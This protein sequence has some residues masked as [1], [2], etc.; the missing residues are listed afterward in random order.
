MNM[1]NSIQTFYRRCTYFVYRGMWETPTTKFQTVLY[2]FLRRLF[3][4]TRLFFRENLQYRASALTYS[5]ILSLV[6]LLAIVFAIA[7]GFGL[8][9]FTE[10]WMRH[11]LVAKP[12]IIDTLVHFVQSYLEHTQ[13]GV[14]LGS[15]LIMLFWTLYNL[16]DSIENTFNRMWQVEQQRSVFRM[17]TDYTAI[18]LLLPVFIVI[19][20]GL[21]IYIYTMA[22]T[23]IPQFTLIRPAAMFVIRLLP[24][25]IVCLFFTALF[26]FMPNTYVRM[27]SALKAGFL[28][29]V[30]FQLL[31]IGY[32]HSQV[33]LTSYDAI[34]GSFAALPLFMLMCQISWMLTL[35]GGTL[36]YVDQNIHSFYYGQDTIHLTRYDHDCLCVRL[37]SAIC[38]RFAKAQPPYTA[39]ELAEN[40][41]IHLRMVT[42]ILGELTRARI[43]MKIGS[44]EKGTNSTYI[45]ATDIHRLTIPYLFSALEQYGDRLKCPQQKEDWKDFYQRRKTIFKQNFQDIPLHKLP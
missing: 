14:F 22:D 5:S 23:W 12:E 20:S 39:T 28:T 16:T 38:K 30:M 32:I 15:G 35:Y 4:T 10:Q 21:T 18:F 31:Q 24:C 36:S 13:G 29:G 1:G 27:K 7:K 40:E 9:A 34:Y 6:P 26:V 11:N 43:L 41:K 25:L 45:P 37:T 33:W 44:G 17:I 19:T 42:D 3:L 2:G 8:S